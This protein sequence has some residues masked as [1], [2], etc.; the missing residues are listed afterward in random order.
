MGIMADIK[1]FP[2][3]QTFRK[4]LKAD[5]LDQ[6]F[7]REGLNFFRRINARDT[8]D[9]PFDT[10]VFLTA[11]PAG[12]HHKVACTVATDNSMYVLIRVHLGTAPKGPARKTFIDFLN[13][14]NA[15]YAIGKYSINEDENVFL[16]ICITARSENFDP[17]VVRTC[18]DL[19][20]FHMGECYD[21]VARRLDKTG[22]QVSEYGL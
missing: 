2:G 22:D 19:L 21:D 7:K 3:N 20:V 11:L 5:I 12:K 14:L 8:R 10:V 17:Y 13:N 4:N 9:D 1:Q 6:Y 16:D 18:L 15:R